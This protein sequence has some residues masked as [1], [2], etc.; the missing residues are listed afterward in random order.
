MLKGCAHYFAEPKRTSSMLRLALCVV[1][2]HSNVKEP[3]VAI[4]VAVKG[5]FH[6]CYCLSS[7]VDLS[8]PIVVVSV[9]VGPEL[10]ASALLL[11]YTLFVIQSQ[12]SK[13][14]SS[15]AMFESCH[16]TG[17]AAT[18]CALDSRTPASRSRPMIPACDP[19]LWRC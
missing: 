17:Q 16:Q 5:C 12:A 4:K 6:S 19:N 11:F 3:V 14:S 2:G 13:S 15:G 7:A 18:R 8:L 10:I 9:F 1:T